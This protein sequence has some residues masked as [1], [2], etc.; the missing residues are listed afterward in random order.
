MYTSIAKKRKNLQPN[1]TLIGRAM[2]FNIQV[3][4]ENLSQTFKCRTRN[5]SDYNYKPQIGMKLFMDYDLYKIF[6]LEI[7]CVYSTLIIQ[8]IYS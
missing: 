5:I 1:E 7:F 4:S 3:L 8:S 6:T 2:K